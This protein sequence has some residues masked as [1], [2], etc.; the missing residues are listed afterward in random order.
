M[1]R[2]FLTCSISAKKGLIPK[3]FIRYQS[4]SSKE[5]NVYTI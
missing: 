3:Q 2:I 5:F 1:D 4:K